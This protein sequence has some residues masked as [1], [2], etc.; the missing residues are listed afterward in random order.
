MAT[1]VWWVDPP[2]NHEAGGWMS[3]KYHDDEVDT[4]HIQN[5]HYYSGFCCQKQWF[6]PLDLVSDHYECWAYH[7]FTKFRIPTTTSGT[8]ESAELY[9]MLGGASLRLTPPPTDLDI[10][11]YYKSAFQLAT[12]PWFTLD[13][14]DYA[15]A[16]WTQNPNSI[17]NVNQIWADFADSFSQ[18]VW[19]TPVV[20]TS[21]VQEA[22]D[23]GWDWAAFRLVPSYLT[24]HDYD[25]D[26]RPT[27]YDQLCWLS[28]YGAVNPHWVAAPLGFPDAYVS[29]CPWLKITYSGGDTQYVPGEDVVTSGEGSAVNCVAADPKA[30]MAIAGTNGGNLWHVWSGGGLWDKIIDGDEAITAVWMDYIRNFQDYPYDEIAWYGTA[31]GNLYKSEDSLGSFNL[32]NT[33]ATQIVEIMSS[34]QDS[35]KIVVGV[36]DG[37]WTSVDG[38]LTW[39]E[40]LEAPTDF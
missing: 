32:M 18:P 30:K 37:V 11:I 16:T 39:T 13:E 36:L 34:N 22:L 21:G 31:S 35:D 14:G 25:W 8:F 5:T 4:V 2:R 27:D 40:S 20:V 6:F 10:D 26:N 38:G 17:E 33:F 29:P 1:E 24:P 12:F 19:L 7:F 9:L 3:H 23:E 28:F 15:S